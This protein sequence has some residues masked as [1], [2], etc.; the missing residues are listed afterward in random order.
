MCFHCIFLYWH[1]R[2]FLGHLD[3]WVFFTRYFCLCN[4]QGLLWPAQINKVKFECPY[5]L[6]KAPFFL[7]EREPYTV[8][9]V[10][11]PLLIWMLGIPISLI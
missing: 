9:G 4:T 1:L 8:K 2:A 11:L 5:V 3:G 10:S 7:G 6:G